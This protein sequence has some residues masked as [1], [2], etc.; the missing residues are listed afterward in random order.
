MNPS[1]FDNP[2]GIASEIEA[3]IRALAVRNTP[4]VRA[5]RC[6]YSRLLQ[7]ADPEFVLAVARALLTNYNHREFA[8]ELIAHHRA[9]FQRIG[10]AELEELGQGIDSWWSVDSL[11]RAL[12]G[13]AW[14]KG[15]VSDELFV[16]WAQS[17]DLWRNNL[18]TGLKNPR[19]HAR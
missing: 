18:N 16:R 19:R 12:A 3:E 17:E 4:N 10:E 14:L 1:I 15:Q 6:G 11:A 9:A 8:Y 13:P 5:I 7:K 2:E